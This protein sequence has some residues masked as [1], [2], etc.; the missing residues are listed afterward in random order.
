MG[1]AQPLRTCQAEIMDTISVL[2]DTTEIRFEDEP[3]IEEALFLWK[4]SAADFSDC[5]IGTRNRRLGCR[6]TATFDVRATAMSGF[7]RV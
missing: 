5:L 2:L 3:A 1:I 7:V 4:D 6:A